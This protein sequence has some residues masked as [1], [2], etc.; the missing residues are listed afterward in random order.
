MV[1]AKLFSTVNLAR[2]SAN[3]MIRVT[4]LLFVI[5]LTTSCQSSDNTNTFPI[6]Q[7]YV[8]DF[9]GILTSEEVNEL[10]EIISNFEDKTSIE[11]AVVTLDSSHTSK[12]SFYT[13][14][15]GLANS[16]GVG[17]ALLNNGVVVAV[18][19]SLRSVRIQNGL[20]IESKLSDK[21]TKQI[22]DNRM[23]P[24]FRNGAFYNGIKQGVE[25]LMKSL[26]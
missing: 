7:G 14:T 8:N 3:N 15:L 11:I 25:E 13:Y 22:I 21:K 5:T 18:S 23:L 9:E 26:R 20:G 17:K 12:D 6:Q 2:P 1:K 24:S 10:D 4:L 16:W 19:K